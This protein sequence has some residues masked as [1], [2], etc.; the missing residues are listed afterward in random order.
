MGKRA[1]M[2]IQG[3]PQQSEKSEY[4]YIYINY[5]YTHTHIHA[6]TGYFYTEKKLALST[7]LYYL[8]LKYYAHI[9][10]IN[11]K[12][13]FQTYTYASKISEV[14]DQPWHE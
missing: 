2:Y 8:L 4:E 9:T 5:I 7:F 11:Q 13:S 1:K 3:F 14:R 6:N 10:F 12:V